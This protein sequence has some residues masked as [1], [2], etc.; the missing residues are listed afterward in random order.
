MLRS[1]VNWTAWFSMIWLCLLSIATRCDKNWQDLH[2]H[3]GIFQ[4][5]W[6]W[7]FF[8]LLQ[9]IQRLLC[10][11]LWL[12][13]GR[14]DYFGQVS[15]HASQALRAC[16]SYIFFRH[17]SFLLSIGL[18]SWYQSMTLLATKRTSCGMNKWSWLWNAYFVQRYK[19]GWLAQIW[20]VCFGE[21][22]DHTKH[23]FDLRKLT[24]KSLYMGGGYEGGMQNVWSFSLP[25]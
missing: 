14:Q 22:G 23:G 11:N 1:F 3:E 21:G 13:E 18:F 4:K 20:V 17:I 25:P 7:M 9:P 15:P 12:R 6:K 19:F 24:L 8:W 2:G 10:S 16:F 5:K